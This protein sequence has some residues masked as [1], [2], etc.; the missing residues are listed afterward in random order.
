[1]NRKRLTQV[2]PALLPIRIAQRKL[3]FYTK[4]N[5][6]SHHYAKTVDDSNLPYFVFSS[7]CNLYNRSTGFPMIYQE[8][9][10]FNLKLIAKKLNGLLIKSGETFSFWQA[11]KGADKEIAFKDGL[12]LENGEL[13]VTYG[14]GLCQMSNLLFWVFL[15]SPLTLLERHT[16]DVK[17]FPTL[18]NDEPEG[19][20]ATVSEGWLDLKVK[21]NTANDFQIV[22]NFLDEYIYGSLYCRNSLPGDYKAEAENLRYVRSEDKIY[23]LVT[24]N[25]LLLDQQGHKVAKEFL[26]ENFCQILYPLNEQEIKTIGG[27]ENEKNNDCRVVRRVLG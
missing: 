26:Y 21:N 6:D 20:D 10:V 14:G 3:F 12:S 13:V 11:V 25:R 7:H 1:M 24:I 23:Q 8:N 18:R 17:E 27:P 19:V 16:H 15:N 9:K 22:I 4:M 2:F 5:L